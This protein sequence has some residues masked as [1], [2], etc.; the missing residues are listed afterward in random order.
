MEEL[1]GQLTFSKLNLFL[2]TLLRFA[3]LVAH[4][5]LVWACV[6][7]LRFAAYIGL[8]FRASRSPQ[9]HHPQSYYSEYF[10][11]RYDNFVLQQGHLHTDSPAVLRF[12]ERS[13]TIECRFKFEPPPKPKSCSC[14]QT[15]R[16]MDG[17]TDRETDRT[18]SYFLRCVGE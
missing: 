4:V 13:V 15:D 11:K 1:V 7:I 17:Q 3:I 6:C 9:G 8:E 18:C 14:R 10:V 12:V 16:Q 2:Q 5:P